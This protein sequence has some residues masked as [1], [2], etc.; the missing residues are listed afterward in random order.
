MQSEIM[1]YDRMRIRI[2]MLLNASSILAS[3]FTL[4][5]HLDATAILP[6]RVAR[7]GCSARACCCVFASHLTHFTRVRVL[8]P[9]ANRGKRQVRKSTC[10]SP[11]RHHRRSSCVCRAALALSQTSPTAAPGAARVLT[12]G[13]PRVRSR[14]RSRDRSPPPPR[15]QAPPPHAGGSAHA[16]LR[17]KPAPPPAPPPL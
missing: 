7:G 16:P 13:L 9:E 5:A 14:S 8:Q 3:P 6:W 15:A 10:W 1:T 17:S 12:Q 2:P 4:L 11:Q